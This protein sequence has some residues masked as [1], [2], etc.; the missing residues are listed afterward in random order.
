MA[1]AGEK[2]V[3]ELRKEFEMIVDGVLPRMKA[4]IE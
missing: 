4:G 2:E 3:A 1:N